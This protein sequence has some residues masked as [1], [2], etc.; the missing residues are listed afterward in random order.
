MKAKLLL[1]KW[2]WIRHCLP[3]TTVSKSISHKFIFAASADMLCHFGSSEMKSKQ[4]MMWKLEFSS[5]WVTKTSQTD[6]SGSTDSDKQG[7]ISAALQG[8]H[9]SEAVPQPLSLEVGKF[10]LRLQ[11][12]T[13]QKK[14]TTTTKKNPKKTPKPA[15]QK[16]PTKK[17]KPKTPKTNQPTKKNC[18]KI[19]QNRNTTKRTPPPPAVKSV[20]KIYQQRNAV[21]EDISDD[22]CQEQC[23]W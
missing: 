9:S 3:R 16:K 10:L 19:Q 13:K 11:G 8:T 6:L 23:P 5:H 7:L 15:P 21:F 12:R 4:C 2:V 18:H 20:F 17:T 1:I 14:K 22:W